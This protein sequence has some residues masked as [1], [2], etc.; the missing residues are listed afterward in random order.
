MTLNIEAAHTSE[1]S[2]TLPTTTPHNKNR[3]NINKYQHKSL[4]SVRRLMF[5]QLVVT[6][7]Y[8]CTAKHLPFLFHFHYYHYSIHLF[9]THDSTTAL[10]VGDEKRMKA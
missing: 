9:L 1:T 10:A 7:E 3:I 2:V 4:K 6:Y 8:K 5:S